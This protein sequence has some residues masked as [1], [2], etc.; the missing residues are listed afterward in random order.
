MKQPTNKI[1]SSFNM[2]SDNH[3]YEIQIHP[4]FIGDGSGLPIVVGFGKG[5]KA[6]YRYASRRL[7]SLAKECEKRGKE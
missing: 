5:E 6:A 1:K 3:D 4:G 7:H 2:G